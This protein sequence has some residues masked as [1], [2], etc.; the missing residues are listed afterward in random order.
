[1]AAVIPEV[2]APPL[3]AVVDPPMEPVKGDVELEKQRQRE[4]MQWR[5]NADK[6]ERARAQVERERAQAERVR[7][8]E[9]RADEARRKAREEAERKKAEPPAPRTPEEIAVQCGRCENE[10]SGW[11]RNKGSS[12]FLTALELCVKKCR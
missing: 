4:A 6:A 9:Q 8:E 2:A 11:R 10:L 5:A 12:A 1:M 3:P 7:L